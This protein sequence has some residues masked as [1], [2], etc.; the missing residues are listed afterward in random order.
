MRYTK[1]IKR[2]VKEKD[3]IEKFICDGPR[4]TNS[5]FN[6]LLDGRADDAIKPHLLKALEELHA[7]EIILR[8][9]NRK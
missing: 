8:E 1:Y 9:K 4:Y 5:P 7:A 3:R 6:S 2:L